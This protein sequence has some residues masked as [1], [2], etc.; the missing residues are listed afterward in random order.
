VTSPIRPVTVQSVQFKPVSQLLSV[1]GEVTT[2]QDSQ[3]GAKRSGRITGVFV[4]DGDAVSAGQLLA[5]L[6]NSDIQSQL[7]QAYAALSG[8]Q[9][10]LAQARLNAK[11]GPMKSSASVAS[12][13]AALR[14][15]K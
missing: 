1:T 13:Q 9:A 14:S 4:K 12:A 7:Q 11:V 5:T 3:I 2:S 6:D 8:A 15:A 10:Q